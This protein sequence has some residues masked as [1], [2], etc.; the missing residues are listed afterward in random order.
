MYNLTQH[1]ASAEQI[2]AGVVDPSPTDK[3]AIVELLTFDSIPTSLDVWQRAHDIL[4]IAKNAGHTQVMIGGAPY[5]ITEMVSQAPLYRLT[6]AH[7]F[8]IRESAE[9]TQPDGSVKKVA[10]FRHMGFV[11]EE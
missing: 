1:P 10:I 5:L 7:A 8:T 6:C 9:I 3:Q 11:F 2:A 4:A